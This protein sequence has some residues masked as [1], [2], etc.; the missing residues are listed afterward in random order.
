MSLLRRLIHW[1]TRPLCGNCYAEVTPIQ[2]YCSDKCR[3]EAMER[4]AW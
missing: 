4:T 2:D 1:L 3:S